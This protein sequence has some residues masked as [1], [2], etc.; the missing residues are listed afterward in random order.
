MDNSI[1]NEIDGEGGIL[2]ARNTPD[3]SMVLSTMTRMAFPPLK[4]RAVTHEYSMEIK[5]VRFWDEDLRHNRKCHNTGI[6]S[7][8]ISGKILK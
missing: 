4:A 7:L 6:S 2:L 1:E 8:I 5:R 3:H